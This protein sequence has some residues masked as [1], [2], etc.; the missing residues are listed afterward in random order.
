M[1]G[2][3]VRWR[4]SLERVALLKV[5]ESRDYA[6]D[7]QRGRLYMNTIDHFRKVEKDLERGDP[8]EGLRILHQG[9][10]IGEI[11]IGEHS[12]APAGVV[13][14]RIAQNRGLHW[15]VFCMYSLHIGDERTARA[16]SLEELRQLLL[17]PTDTG[18]GRHLAVVTDRSEFYRRVDAAARRNNFSLRRRLVTYYDETESYSFGE[19]E[20]PFQK[21]RLFGHQREYRI[22]IDRGEGARGPYS[23]DV[24]AL[25]DI[26]SLTTV[27][28][29][30]ATFALRLPDGTQAGPGVPLTSR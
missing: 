15:N 29:F 8:Y 30:N 13:N 1:D 26:V 25:G 27:E 10:D 6:E 20:F 2:A 3:S 14:V 12:I 18:L 22:V 5:V 21:R 17:L 9:K 16:K 28:E 11:R 19:D 24:G 4:R 7:F 23:L